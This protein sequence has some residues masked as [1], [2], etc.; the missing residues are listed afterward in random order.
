MIDQDSCAH[1]ATIR[2]IMIFISTYLEFCGIATLIHFA[3]YD[4]D[5]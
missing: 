3:V 4:I 5:V 2:Q 1:L